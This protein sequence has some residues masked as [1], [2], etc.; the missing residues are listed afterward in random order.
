MACSRCCCPSAG[1][2]GASLRGSGQ[3]LRRGQI[4]STPAWDGLT[5]G[6]SLGLDCPQLPVGVL[7]DQVDARLCVAPSVGP[8]FPQPHSAK[9][10]LREWIIGQNQLQTRS[11]CL[12][13]TRGSGSRRANRSL[14]VA[15]KEILAAVRT[16][17]VA[18]ES[19]SEPNA[20]STSSPT[21]SR[22]RSRPRLGSLPCGERDRAVQLG[23]RV[24]PG[25]RC[26]RASAGPGRYTSAVLP[27][28]RYPA[29]SGT[30]LAT[31][32]VAAAVVSARR[33]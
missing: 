30:S 8:P 17:V 12:R 25:D 9:P 3:S 33:S 10:R 22:Y 31:T 13:P 29:N 14:N 27:G 24:E 32:A 19:A 21:A 4:S 20:P 6:V 26:L 1:F 23:L 18:H 28:S 15:T 2:A 5:V 16:A 11:N 7:G